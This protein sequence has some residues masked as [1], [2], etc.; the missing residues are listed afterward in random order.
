MDG[1]DRC[2]SQGDFLVRIEFGFAHGVI[3]FIDE[4]GT[5]VPGHETRVP[6]DPLVKGD[7]GL[8]APHLIFAQR[9]PHPQDR[10]HTILTPYD[11]LCDHRII[12]NRHL[13]SLIDA[14]IVSHAEPFRQSEPFDFAWI[15]HEIMLGILGINPAFDG[16]T[17]LRDVTLSPRQIA[18]CRHFD[19]GFHQVDSNHPFRDRVL[20]LESRIHFE[21]I[22]VFLLVQKKFE[23]PGAHVTH[24]SGSLDRDAPDTPPGPIV[25][26]GRGRFFDDFLMTSLDRAFTVI[27][28][29]HPAVFVRQDLNLHVPRF[30]NVL[31]YIEPRVAE[32]RG[33]LRSHRAVSRRNFSGRANQPQPLATTAGHG[34]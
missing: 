17:G 32:G 11:Q 22:E 6:Q 16:M 2:G 3:F 10:F 19:L 5:E 30:L 23:G 15:G 18:T 21:K 24:R 1:G 7:I 12:V 26:S 13:G 27:E 14:A 33:C 4:T 25:H 20:D 8:Y 29:N 31:F 28:M 34:L 9:P